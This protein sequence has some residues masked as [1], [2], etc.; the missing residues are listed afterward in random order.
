MEPLPTRLAIGVLS[1]H[2]GSRVETIRYYEHVE[3][4]PR[5]PRSPGGYR[6]YERGGLER[7]AFIRRARA[8]GFSLNEVRR[9]LRVGPMGAGA[10]APRP[11]CWRPVISPTDSQRSGLRR[12]ERVLSEAVARCGTGTGSECARI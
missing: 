5:P 10:R 8:L 7:L 9:L 4:F 6:Q 1:Q 12:M 2:T 11:A 3:L